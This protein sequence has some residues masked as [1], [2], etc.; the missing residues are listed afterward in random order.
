[1]LGGRIVAMLTVLATAFAIAVLVPLH[2]ASEHHGEAA[3]THEGPDHRDS[4]HA[5]LAVGKVAPA[6]L[7]L[8][9]MTV[10]AA[11]PG[12]DILAAAHVVASRRSAERL[13]DPPELN[14][15][16]LPPTPPRAPPTLRT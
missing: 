16:A 12:A 14:R 15:A 1:M 10:L 13:H 2:L 9:P 6:P 11:D 8:R 5:D 4:D 7:D 3:E